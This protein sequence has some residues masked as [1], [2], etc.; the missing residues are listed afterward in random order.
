MA[1]WVYVYIGTIPVGSI[2]TGAIISAAG[3]GPPC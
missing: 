1:L 3:A 2:I